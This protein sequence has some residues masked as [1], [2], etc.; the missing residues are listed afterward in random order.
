MDDNNGRIAEC[1]E[2]TI[3]P[4]HYIPRDKINEEHILTI[5]GTR[6]RHK[7]DKIQ[8]EMRKCKEM[9]SKFSVFA[10]KVI[11]NGYITAA[12]G[13]GWTLGGQD[14]TSF[15]NFKKYIESSKWDE[16]L[17]KNLHYLQYKRFKIDIRLHRWDYRLSDEFCSANKIKFEHHVAHEQGNDEQIKT[18]TNRSCF[19]ILATAIKNDYNKKLR[20]ICMMAHGECIKER[21]DGSIER[22][23]T[24]TKRH[25]HWNEK[26]VCK[27]SPENK[28]KSGNCENVEYWKREAETLKQQVSELKQKLSDKDEDEGY[29][30]DDVF[31]SFKCLAHSAI[32]SIFF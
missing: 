31:V 28:N 8:D 25:F 4:S 13:M 7:R 32:Y 23:E 16:K 30:F 5:I 27:V 21:Q 20:K 24:S 1:N 2:F 6:N 3:I 14:L 18:A 22:E 9:K 29:D 12:K 26:Y 17:Q 15:S 10:R 19:V 11:M